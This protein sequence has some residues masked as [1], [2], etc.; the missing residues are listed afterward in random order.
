MSAYDSLEDVV[1]DPLYPDVDLALRGGRHI[2]AEDGPLY[3]F[4]HDA[5]EHLEP[6]Y[7]RFGAELIHRSDGYYF[8]LPSGERLGRSRLSP[9]EM[10]VGQALALLY[11]D[12]SI[13]RFGGVV[14]RELLLQRLWGL[15]GSEALARALEPRRRNFDDERIVNQTIMKKVASALR[16]LGKLGFI[17]L[18]GDDQLKLRPAL[19][20]FVEPVR[21]LNDPS[22]ALERLMALGELERDAV[23]NDED[24]EESAAQE[25]E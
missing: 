7:R 24:L 11:L 17:D 10:L 25:D 1:R 22:A 5:L 8:L 18:L 4:L 19:M 6:L 21:G 20:R 13:L 9:G 16:A 12:P 2:G 14:A 15:V 3:D 23:S